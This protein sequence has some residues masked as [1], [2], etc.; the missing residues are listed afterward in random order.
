VTATRTG[1]LRVAGILARVD[2]GVARHFEDGQKAREGAGADLHLPVSKTARP[3]AAQPTGRCGVHGAFKRCLASPSSPSPVGTIDC[4]GHDEKDSQRAYRVS[5]AS[6]SGIPTCSREGP[7]RVIRRQSDFQSR[8]PLLN[9][10]DA[11]GRTIINHRR[12]NITWPQQLQ[13]VAF[14]KSLYG[15][16]EDLPKRSRSMDP[17]PTKRTGLPRYR[18]DDRLLIHYPFVPT[19]A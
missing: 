10:R 7:I 13:N 17:K 1:K 11:L 5:I 9:K 16:I 12:P 4:F 8:Q 15:F 3:A 14:R 18:L 2:C 6:I 19:A